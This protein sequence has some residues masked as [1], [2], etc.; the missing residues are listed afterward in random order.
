MLLTD[1]S[2]DVRRL[3]TTSAASVIIES[4]TLYIQEIFKMVENFIFSFYNFLNFSLFTL[5]MSDI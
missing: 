1:I 5:S 3:M 4:T 2:L